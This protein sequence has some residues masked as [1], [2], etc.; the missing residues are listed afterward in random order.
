MSTMSV[1]SHEDG[2]SALPVAD[3]LR[4]VARLSPAQRTMLTRLGEAGEPVT[5][6][7]IATDVG[8]RASTARETL[9]GLLA[10]GLIRRERMPITGPGRPSFGYVA[11]APTGIEG[12]MGMFVGLVTATADTLRDAVP[13]PVETAGAIGEA[14]ADQMVGGAL[15]DHA[16][17]PDQAYADLDLGE[18]LDKIAYFFTAL[19]FGASVGDT[20]QDICLRSCPFLR[21]GVVDPL[22]C[23]MHRGMTRRVIDRTSRGRVQAD[24]RPWVT[25]DTCLVEV[26]DAD[27]ESTTP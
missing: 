12:P 8:V 18:H 22:V 17:H 1:Q 7:T 9:D 5:V 4:R 24:L 23:Q 3:A 25:P 10:S 6:A 20:R 13:D 16:A 15:P 26:T 21:D 11:A 2:P 27:G 19:G 14:W